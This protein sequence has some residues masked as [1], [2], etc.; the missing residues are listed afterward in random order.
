VHFGSSTCTPGIDRGM[1]GLLCS[2]ACADGALLSSYARQVQLGR[3]KNAGT[4]C[5][6]VLKALDTHR[7][8]VGGASGMSTGLSAEGSECLS[9]GVQL[10]AQL[11]EAIEAENYALAAELRDK[12]RQLQV[13][14]SVCTLCVHIPIDILS[15]LETSCGSLLSL[16]S[17]TTVLTSPFGHDDRSHWRKAGHRLATFF[18]NYVRHSSEWLHCIAG[19]GGRPVSSST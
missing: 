1:C 10:Q 15:S 5:A 7:D 12:V 8:T 19:F 9:S 13:R 2:F 6:Q 3:H 11:Q 17:A 14:H 16:L 18:C 4:R